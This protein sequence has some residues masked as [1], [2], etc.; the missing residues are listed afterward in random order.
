M[1]GGIKFDKD[2]PEMVLI[3]VAAKIAM[4]EAFGY[5][6]KKY[7]KW[8][9]KK[10]MDWT[11]LIS[12][13]ERHLDAFKECEDLDPESGILHLGHALADLAM[14]VD[15]YKNKLGND[16]R[17]KSDDNNTGNSDRH[18]KDEGTQRT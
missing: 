16:D 13:T 5:G 17:F 12:A 7:G 14:L 4:A 10:G 3:P 2:K 6:A 11:R 1:S 8:N 15:Y 18:G 9:Y